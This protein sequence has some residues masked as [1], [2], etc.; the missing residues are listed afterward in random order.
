MFI[1]KHKENDRTASWIN[2]LVGNSVPTIAM[3]KSCGWSIIDLANWSVE[4]Y[5]AKGY[6]DVWISKHGKANANVYADFFVQSRRHV[7][8]HDSMLRRSNTQ[9]TIISTPLYLRNPPE[10]LFFFEVDLEELCAYFATL[11]VRHAELL[12]VR[13]HILYNKNN[14]VATIAPSSE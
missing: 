13:V 10:A 7:S 14:E 3:A 2:S 6:H 11:A 8:E 4:Q 12:G 1:S 9:I 5:C